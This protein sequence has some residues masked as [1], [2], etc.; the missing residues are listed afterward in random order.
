MAHTRSET[1]WP[2]ETVGCHENGS[3][4]AEHDYTRSNYIISCW[5][6]YDLH[7]FRMHARIHTLPT[8]NMNVLVCAVC[9]RVCV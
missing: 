1:V 7:R 9:V 4:K 5:R 3:R 2:A 6:K 8:V